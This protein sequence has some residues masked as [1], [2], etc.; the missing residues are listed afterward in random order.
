MMTTF[1]ID[2]GGLKSIVLG[3]TNLISSPGLNLIEIN[4]VK[5]GPPTR[6]TFSGSTTEHGYSNLAA[7]YSYSLV[8]G[9]L[10]IPV[11]IQNATNDWLTNFRFQLP[12]LNIAG[13]ITTNDKWWGETYVRQNNEGAP[14]FQHP[15]H[16][17]YSFGPTLGSAIHVKSHFRSQTLVD[18][19]Q[20]YVNCTIPPRGSATINVVWNITADTSL[21]GLFGPYRSDYVNEIGLTTIP[22]DSRIVF[23]AYVS[24][25]PKM[26]NPANPYGYQ[27]LRLD[28]PGGIDA[29][30]AM[31]KPAIGKTQGMFIVDPQG[32][33]SRGQ[34]IRSEWLDTLPPETLDNLPTLFAWGKTNGVS[35][36]IGVRPSAVI[37]PENFSTDQS[38][39]LSPD[40]YPYV[41]Q[42]IKNAMAMGIGEPIY[43]DTLGYSLADANLISYMRGIIGTTIKTYSEAWTAL[44]IKDSGA[45][46]PGPVGPQW[47]SA[48]SFTD[49]QLARFLQPS[50]NIISEVMQVDPA[51]HIEACKAQNIAP[52]F[53]VDEVSTVIPLL[54]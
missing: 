2:S 12:T 11:T 26:V 30:I 49:C 25:N 10:Q 47:N 44:S 1:S 14:D 9:V 33:Q 23:Q 3:G 15:T 7:T 13:P 40:Q 24:T 5:I 22:A 51:A 34:S 45:Y 18:S 19:N 4:G 31:L 39:T 35:I 21:P 54:P 53:D 43:F 8:N 17:F 32:V 29:A 27:E 20:L 6:A 42:R 37:V 46:A 36:G 50:M 48:Y 28:T 52:L 16:A 41:G 38:W